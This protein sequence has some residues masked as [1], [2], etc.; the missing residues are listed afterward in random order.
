[1][2]IEVLKRT[3]SPKQQWLVSRV[4]P[5]RPRLCPPPPPAPPPRRK[6]DALTYFSLQ[7]RAQVI[8]NPH[9]L[10][11]ALLLCNAGCYEALPLFLA[12]LL[13]PAAAIVISVTAILIIGEILPQAVCKRYGLEIGAHLSWLVRLIMLLTFPVS[14]SLGRLLDWAL[15][16]ETVFFRRPE[17]R[18]L[19]A[20]HAE[21][22]HG[23]GESA[24]TEEDAKV[25]HGALDMAHKTAENAMTPFERV[26]VVHADAVLDRAVLGEVVHSGHSRVPVYEGAD[27]KVGRA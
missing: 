6:P 14:W 20:L 4:E 13:S 11:V 16:E 12:R 1:V 23:G 22:E 18:A 19:V 24:L 17:L 27:K 2:D 15:G 5:V 9:R 25:I 3:G 21:T 7:N 8:A 10:M 26:T